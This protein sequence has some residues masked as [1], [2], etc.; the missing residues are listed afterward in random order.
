MAV[1]ETILTTSIPCV[2]YVVQITGLANGANSITISN[3]PGVLPAL[4][5]PPDGQW[6]P[7]YVWPF[8]YNTA[9][10]GPTVTVDPTTIANSAGTITFTLYSSGSGSAWCLV[11]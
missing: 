6:T 2:V 4:T 10:I 5:F 1:A 8:P 9:A 7:T 3:T 11:F